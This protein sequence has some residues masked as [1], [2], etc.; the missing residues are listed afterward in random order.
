MSTVLCSRTRETSVRS[1]QRTFEPCRIPYTIKL[2]TVNSGR[3]KIFVN[4]DF[5][6]VRMV[7]VTHVWFV[8]KPKHFIVIMLIFVNCYQTVFVFA[9]HVFFFISFLASPL[10][11]FTATDNSMKTR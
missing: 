3:V 1:S 11:I 9:I 8:T 2:A 6:Q 5:L 7:L 10:K 4:V